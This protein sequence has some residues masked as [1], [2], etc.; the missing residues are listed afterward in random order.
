MVTWFTS[1]RIVSF[2]IQSATSSDF[3][4]LAAKAATGADCD[5]L[6]KNVY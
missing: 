4:P 2:S 6:L 1:G 5:L 3:V